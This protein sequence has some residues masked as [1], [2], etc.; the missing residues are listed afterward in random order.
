[1]ASAR[2]WRQPSPSRN[3]RMTKISQEPP[4]DLG[5]IAD[6]STVAL[7]CRLRVGGVHPIGYELVRAG[8]EEQVIDAKQG[9]LGSQT[10][11]CAV[12]RSRHHSSATGPCSHWW[13]TA[14]QR[15]R[16][17]APS[18]STPGSCRSTFELT[19]QRRQTPAGDGRMICTAAWSRQTVA[20]VAGPVVERVVRHHS[21]A[22]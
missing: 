3:R 11:P 6:T 17:F 15:L 5:R 18:N 20:A 7:R 19:G 14:L 1:M 10:S 13:Q 9:S 8:Q 22:C 2:S 4:S 21:A 12:W 16:S